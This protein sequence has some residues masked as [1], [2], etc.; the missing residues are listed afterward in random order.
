VRLPSP[1]EDLSL[2][3]LTYHV[4]AIARA[5]LSAAGLDRSIWR[6]PVVLL[7]DVRSVGVQGDERTYGHPFV[8]GPVCSQEGVTA[9]WSRLPYDGLEAISTRITNEGRDVNRIVLDLTSKPAGTIEWEEPPPT[10]RALLLRSMPGAIPTSSPVS[11]PDRDGLALSI[12]ANGSCLTQATRSSE[13]VRN[14]HVR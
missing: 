10:S 2:V 14:E 12:S 4:D 7:A 9:H 13:L 5:E 11:G 1:L 8:L 3:E 6:C